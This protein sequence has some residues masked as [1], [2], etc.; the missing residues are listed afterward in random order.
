MI[1]TRK[2]LLVIGALWLIAG[3]NVVVIGIAALQHW[4]TWWV[5]LGAVGVFLVFEIFI[6]SRVAT[7]YIERVLSFDKAKTAFWHAFDIKGYV[8]I[9]VMMGGGIALRALGIAPEWFI[10]LFYSGLGAALC[11]SGFTYVYVYIKHHKT[12]SNDDHYASASV[13]FSKKP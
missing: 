4:L 13:P 5:V 11:V 12:S 3:V 2:L 1:A 7:R 6:F 8:T 9:V 10:A